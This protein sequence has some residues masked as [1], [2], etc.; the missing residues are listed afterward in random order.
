[1]LLPPTR[2]VDSDGCSIAYQVLGEGPDVLFVPGLVSHLDL[3]WS[4]P[5]FADALR[6]LASFSRLIIFDHRGVGLS[7]PSP[8]VTRLEQ[9]V[10]DMRAVL[11]AVE[12]DQATLLGHCNGGPAS[13]LFAATYPDRVRSM[14]MAGSNLRIVYSQMNWS[15]SSSIRA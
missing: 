12:S 6:R 9:R 2:H 7:D 15:F 13:L 11:D 5:W 1:M 4:D 14:A 10:G 8:G 3:H